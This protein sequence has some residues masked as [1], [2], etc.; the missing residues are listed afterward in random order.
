M[1]S[2]VAELPNPTNSLRGVFFMFMDV[3]FAWGCLQ[4]S[5][6]V[7]GQP[8]LWRLLEHSGAN[9]KDVQTRSGCVAPGDPRFGVPNDPQ[10]RKVRTLLTPSIPAKGREG[11]MFPMK[12][13]W[14]PS[15]FHP[16]I[17]A[18]AMSLQ[19][20]DFLASLRRLRP[21]SGHEGCPASQEELHWMPRKFWNISKALQSGLGGTR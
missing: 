12:G 20:P 15:L 5:V 6:W 17:S 14:L 10:S 4:F 13:P 18:P 9:C 16:T 7:E 21:E 8:A 11:V 2:S 19:G 3:F 1:D